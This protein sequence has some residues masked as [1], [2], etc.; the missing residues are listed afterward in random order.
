MEYFARIFAALSEL[1]NAAIG[2]HN[3]ETISARAWRNRKR[4]GWRVAYR[5][6]NAV[7]FW[8]E[9]HCYSSR[10]ADVKWHNEF[11]ELR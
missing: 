2:G 3:N 5:V 4:P 11:K 10:Q 7:F 9:D 6:I 8:Q 1:V